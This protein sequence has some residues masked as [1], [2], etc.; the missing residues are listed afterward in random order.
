[1]RKYKTQAYS[2]EVDLD[3]PTTY[4][5]LPQTVSELRDLMFK[6]I[7]YSHCY[8]HYWHTKFHKNQRKKVK[9]MIK[10]FADNE[11]ENHDNVL[12]FQEQVFLF[13]DEIENLC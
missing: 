6:E 4:E 9:T 12:W 11:R 1:M 2:D 10:Y 7:G 13:Q 5:H 8:L 3:N